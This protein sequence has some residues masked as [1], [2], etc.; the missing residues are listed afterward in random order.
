MYTYVGMYIC[1]LYYVNMKILKQLYFIIKKDMW[2]FFLVKNK[3]P[4]T[5]SAKSTRNISQPLNISSQV[6]NRSQTVTKPSQAAVSNQKHPATKPVQAADAT[7]ASPTTGSVHSTSPNR[8]IHCFPPEVGG[9]VI[10]GGD[11]SEANDDEPEEIDVETS[12]TCSG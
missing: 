8:L 5:K 7:A 2:F 10:A 1:R 12:T 6:Q 4:E 11:G 9:V 3:T